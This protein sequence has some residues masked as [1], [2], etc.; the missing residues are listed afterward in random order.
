MSS[1]AIDFD[2]Y[3][4]PRIRFAPGAIREVGEIA[5]GFGHKA[6]LVTGGS[7]LEQSGNLRR[8]ESCL[9]DRGVEFAHYRGVV[10]E[11]GV[12]AV[13]RGVEMGRRE[14]VDMV[15]A[16]G[17]GSVL[18]VGKA[19]AGLITNGG[20]VF[21]Y[22]EGVGSGRKI[23]LPSLP[24]V[25][26]PTTAGTGSEATKNAVIRSRE[27]RFKKSIRH[28]HLIPRVALLD[29][30]LTIG[31]P[32]AVTAQSGMDAL[33]QL[34]ETY[35][36]KKARPISDAL[37]IHGIR[38]AAR[39]LPRACEGGDD[40]E[41]RSDMLLA[42]LLS[43]LALANAGLGAAHGVG[44][45]LGALFGVPHGL[46]CAIMLPHVFRL[47]FRTNPRKFAEVGEALVGMRFSDSAKAA[48]AG[49]SFIA[50]LSDTI[51]I[52]G[53]LRGLGIARADVPAVVKASRGTSMRGN[54]RDLS[55]AELA[56]LLESLL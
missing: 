30:E 43:G 33:T 56:A 38:L 2:F 41:A 44:A 14:S 17:G 55:D 49:A 4:P 40:L 7:S 45:A 54:P 16:V 26:V 1:G 9:R 5:A 10:G 48:E 34:I 6:L 39:A 31:L 28:E 3:S 23:T 29:P 50:E 19:V 27:A 47:N 22:L 52:P 21:D 51:G 24:F 13:D 46:A 36:S 20:S 8:I 32:P 53:N 15:F 12:D 42:A 37:A 18:D 25:A 35:T 11:P